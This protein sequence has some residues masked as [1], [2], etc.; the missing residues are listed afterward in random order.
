MPL[1]AG[2]AQETGR[3][4]AVSGEATLERNGESVPATEGF[5]ILF[6][7]VITLD[8]GAAARGTA[9]GGEPFAFRGP[10]RFL[11]SVGTEENVAGAAVIKTISDYMSRM[12]DGPETLRGARDWRYTANAPE[13]LFPA[14][15]G[16]V[17]TGGGEFF[18]T[19]I[20]GIDRYDVMITPEGGNGE[21]TIEH[22]VEGYQLAVADLEPGAE[23]LWKVAVRKPGLVI[24][25]NWRFFTVMTEEEETRLDRSLDGLRDFEAGVLLFVNGLYREAIRRF[26]AAA[27]QDADRPF[28]L[29]WR[30]RAFRVIGL[31]ENAYWDLYE[32]VET[33]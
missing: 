27:A 18:W 33:E 25:S 10:F 28:A 16:R 12:D 11:F 19:M 31:H 29:Y 21:E 9:P 1:P 20:D 3:I 13:L 14:P 5:T 7:D 6:G 30:A 17:R 8:P 4:D 2:A 23:Y 15:N 26:D 22:T 24:S 32:I